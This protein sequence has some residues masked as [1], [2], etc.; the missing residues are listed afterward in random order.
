MR[1]VVAVVC[2]VVLVLLHAADPLVCPDGC[3]DRPQKD[4]M[5]VRHEGRTQPIGDCLLCNG[6]LTSPAV[7][8]TPIPSIAEILVVVDADAVTV[9]RPR[10]QLEHPP[11]F[12]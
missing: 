1:S 10:P 6:G 12:T 8:P 7:I 2:L 4:A 3:T 9:S 5:S 11:R